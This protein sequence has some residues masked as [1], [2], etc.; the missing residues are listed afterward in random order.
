MAN[1][2]GMPPELLILMNLEKDGGLC[3]LC[4]KPWKKVVVKNRFADNYYFDPDCRCY[5]K[6]KNCG[7]SMHRAWSLGI[8]TCGCGWDNTPKKD[9]IESYK[10]QFKR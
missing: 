3:P 5:P 9:S 4:K 10:S 1:E 7:R 2:A 6:C 8:N